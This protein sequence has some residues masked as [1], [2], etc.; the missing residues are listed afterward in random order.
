MAQRSEPRGPGDG[1][2]GKRTDGARLLT[3]LGT[4]SGTSMDGIDVALVRTDGETRVERGP[5][6]TVPFPTALRRRI[7]AGLGDAAAIERRTDRPGGLAALEAEITD[8]HAAAIESFLATHG[9]RAGEID[10]VGVHGQTVLHDAARALTVQLIDAGGL[11]R[12]TG[13]RIVHDIRQRDIEAGG[14]GAPL[15]PLYHRALAR[16][17]LGVPPDVP[18]AFL[19]LGGIG[20]L[21][22]IDGD[23]LLAFD[24]GPGCGLLDQ[25]VQRAGLPYDDGGRIAGEGAIDRP[26]LDRFLAA[27]FFGL[28]GPR[29]LDRNDF[30]LP[31]DWDAE[32]SDGARTLARLTAEAVGRSAA[33]LPRLP[34]RWIVSGGG[35]RHPVVMADL[36]DV[37][38]P[39]SVEAA[40]G[41]GLSGDAMEA[42]AWAFLAVRA[43][44]GLHVS[45]PGTTGRRPLAEDRP[46]YA[47]L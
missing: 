2:T 26:T 30:R 11:A 15:V 6:L 14:Q 47:W 22:F 1:S 40:D 21:S 24:T 46:K 16:G 28:T 36:A 19:N 33:G 20:N 35:A 42:E 5:S 37:L 45:E 25:W 34:A 39:A 23:A 44:Q 18:V 29:S 8:R 3:A 12:A 38:A 4:M 32:L 27:P 13:M 43:A 10:L 7:E 31:P 17:V 9:L 41:C